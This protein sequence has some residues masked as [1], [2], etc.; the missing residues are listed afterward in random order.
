MAV[1]TVSVVVKSSFCLVAASTVASELFRAIAAEQCG[2]E[3]RMT[4][5]EKLICRPSLDICGPQLLDTIWD[6]HKVVLCC[7]FLKCSGKAGST[8]VSSF[9]FCQRK[10][11]AAKFCLQVTA[12]YSQVFYRVSMGFLAK[13]D[14]V[15]RNSKIF[16]DLV[17]YHILPSFA[18]LYNF[19]SCLVLNRLVF[20]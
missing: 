19:C 8:L 18:K 10:R 13:R 14:L 5:S 12:C 16:R 11:S 3:V 1:S 17:L 9:W 2:G 6:N 7:L 15:F 20:F 4:V